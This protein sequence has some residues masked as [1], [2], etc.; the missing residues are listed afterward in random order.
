MA[1]YDK[2]EFRNVDNERPN[3]FFEARDG[4]NVIH[5][6]AFGTVTDAGIAPVTW[7][8]NQQEDSTEALHSQIDGMGTAEVHEELQNKTL[9]EQIDYINGKV[10]KESSTYMDYG[11]LRRF[12]FPKAVNTNAVIR[13]TYKGNA[14]VSI[15]RFNGLDI[16]VGGFSG[17][18]SREDGTSTSYSG[19]GAGNAPIQV[20]AN[21]PPVNTYFVHAETVI[22][23]VNEYGSDFQYITMNEGQSTTHYSAQITGY[24]GDNTFSFPNG[25]TSFDIQV[26]GNQ[27]NN[28]VIPQYIK[29]EVTYYD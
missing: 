20:V 23:R 28:V 21:H 22:N 16:T 6:P 15:T 3:T 13:V 5:T 12:Y 2:T 10:Y 4:N 27:N 1:L 26:H 18:L 9:Q 29:I 8:L 11:E 14:A 7:V 24:V 19:N 17:Y 25:I